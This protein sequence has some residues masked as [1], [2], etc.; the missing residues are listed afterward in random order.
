MRYSVKDRQ[1]GKEVGHIV[2]DNINTASKLF[3]NIYS[4][5]TDDVFMTD[6]T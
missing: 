1:T 3:Y 2:A 5:K 6:D 4:D